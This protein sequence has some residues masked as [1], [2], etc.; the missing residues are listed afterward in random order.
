MVVCMC[1]CVCVCACVC[2]R[3]CVCVCACVPVCVCARARVSPKAPLLKHEPR[4]YSAA[5]SAPSLERLPKPRPCSAASALYST[6]YTTANSGALH[7]TSVGSAAIEPNVGP[8]VCTGRLHER[9]SGAAA[10]PAAAACCACVSGGIA[11]RGCVGAW[12][13]G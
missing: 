6:A 4:A 12:V 5:L 8:G 11:V 1:V 7:S 10:P 2:V 13:G 3:V 9:R